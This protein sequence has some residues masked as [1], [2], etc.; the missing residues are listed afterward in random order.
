MLTVLCPACQSKQKRFNS[1]VWYKLADWDARH[2]QD[3]TSD[4]ECTWEP[5]CFC[6]RCSYEKEREAHK[7]ALEAEEA[8]IN[9]RIESLAQRHYPNGVYVP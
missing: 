9:A 2:W 6:P 4:E 8:A 3:D 7:A 1:G 5:D